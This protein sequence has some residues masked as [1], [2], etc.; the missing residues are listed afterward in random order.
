MEKQATR[1]K[2]IIDF[3]YWTLVLGIGFVAIS[4][5]TKYL[6]PFVIGFLIAFLLKPI[7]HKITEK[8]G[9]KKWISLLVILAFYAVF[10]FLL[11]WLFVGLFTSI[12]RFA[13]TLPSFY[14]NTLYPAL[15]QMIVY[16]SG[17]VEDLNPSI[18]SVLDEITGSLF[19]SLEGIVKMLSSGALNVLTKLVSAVPSL[20]VSVS[21]AIISSFFFTMDYQKLV[22]VPL[23]YVPAKQ[24]L[25]LLD[26]KESLISVLGKYLRAYAILMSLTFVELSIGFFILKVNNPVGV[27][28][29][30]AAVDIL[31]VFGTGGVVIPWVIVEAVTGNI[32]FAIGLAILYLIITLI[33]NILEPKVVGDQIG[34]HPLLTLMSIFVGVKLFGFWGL[35]AFPVGITILKSLHDDGKIEIFKNIRS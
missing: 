7:V 13:K 26:I 12:Q 21:V 27:A 17:F 5:T 8:L 2:F 28:A 6:M 33:R 35:V 3:V 18:L 11:F 16:F 4:F 30:I 31:P 20:L 1:K 32:S 22:R 10:A 24:R 19:D 29:A 25:L 34:L 9:D 23:S 15:E 14:Q